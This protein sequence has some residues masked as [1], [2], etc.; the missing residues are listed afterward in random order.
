[1]NSES[2]VKQTSEAYG[3]SAGPS[4]A[5]THGSIAPIAP[6]SSGAQADSGAEAAELNSSSNSKTKKERGP[7]DHDPIEAAA[8][9]DRKTEKL[10]AQ[11]PNPK[12]AKLESAESRA[13]WS[14]VTKAMATVCAEIPE[15]TEIDQVTATDL[16]LLQNQ[17]V[18]GAIL[19]FSTEG[20][21]RRE[22]I[23][24]FQ[25][26]LFSHLRADGIEIA[27]NEQTI[28]TLDD[29]GFV[30]EC[31]ESAEVKACAL[32]MQRLMGAAMVT[33]TKVEPDVEAAGE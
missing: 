32:S 18:Q 13:F 6:G 22:L 7:L 30:K 11:L 10:R 16:L 9:L 5:S 31:Y 4:A 14:Y 8:S 2:N 23:D 27:S 1:N 12:S 20:H 21:D 3:A 19:I 33:T 15:K 29:I 24:R 26:A 17:R 28:V 25:V